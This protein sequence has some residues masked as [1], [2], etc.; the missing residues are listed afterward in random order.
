M[1]SVCDL[2]SKRKRNELSQAPHSSVPDLSARKSD[3][4]LVDRGTES[5]TLAGLLLH[6]RNSTDEEEVFRQTSK[7]T[8]IFICF[9]ILCFLKYAENST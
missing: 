2:A 8:K 3:P 1:F 4:F 5:V 6:E 9:I 7:S